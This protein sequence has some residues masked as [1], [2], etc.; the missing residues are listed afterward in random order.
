MFK[1][2]NAKIDPIMNGL[3]ILKFTYN[4]YITFIDSFS[5]MQVALKK[6]PRMF[7][8]D[9]IVDGKG[10]YPYYFNSFDN[11]NY[12]G[13]FPDKKYFGT[14]EFEF[15]GDYFLSFLPPQTLLVLFL[16]I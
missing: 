4:R 15:R 6:L 3:I 10:Y 14:H 13:K 7:G 11:Y 16:G 5:F 2:R 1:R 12:I 9:D 8:F